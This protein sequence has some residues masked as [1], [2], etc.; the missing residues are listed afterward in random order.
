[1]HNVCHLY[2]CKIIVCFYIDLYMVSMN[3]LGQ[4]KLMVVVMGLKTSWEGYKQHFLSSPGGLTHP[5]WFGTNHCL[6]Q[7]M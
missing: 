4:S 5:R 1:M 3:L 7:I 2:E 6:N